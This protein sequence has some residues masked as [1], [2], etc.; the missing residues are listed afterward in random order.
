MCRR[1]SGSELIFRFQTLL[2]SCKII[3]EFTRRRRDPSPIIFQEPTFIT[4]AGLW[5]QRVLLEYVVILVLALP[6][7]TYSRS[8]SR[9]VRHPNYLCKEAAIK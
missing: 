7:V 3:S 9:I 4:P 2:Y 8:S 5:F 6:T 1:F